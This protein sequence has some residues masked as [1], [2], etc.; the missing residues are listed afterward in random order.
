MPSEPS[1][2]SILA[3]FLSISPASRRRLPSGGEDGFSQDR[4]G[5]STLPPGG[6]GVGSDGPAPVRGLRGAFPQAEL[7][8]R[9]AAGGAVAVSALPRGGPGHGRQRVLCL[10]AVAPELEGGVLFP[11]LWRLPP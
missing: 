8:V 3:A 4:G 7:A 6:A 11:Q 2:G 5:A 1:P 9:T 10:R